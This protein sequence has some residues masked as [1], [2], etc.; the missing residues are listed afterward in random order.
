ML[1][2]ISVNIIMTEKRRIIT[3]TKHRSQPQEA[4]TKMRY[5]DDFRIGLDLGNDE[6]DV[7]E[8]ILSGLPFHGYC[9]FLPR[10]RTVLTPSIAQMDVELKFN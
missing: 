9:Q 4:T 2:I 10:R 6:E 8:E 5:S 3:E 1:M 7:S